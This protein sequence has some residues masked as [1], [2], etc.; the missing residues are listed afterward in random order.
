MV[1]VFMD[2]SGKVKRKGLVYFT[3]LMAAITMANSKTMKLVVLVSTF[4]LTVNI[5][6]VNG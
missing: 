1:H 4:G 3:L 5:I 6:V 2:N